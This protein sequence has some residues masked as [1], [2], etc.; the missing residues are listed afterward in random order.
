MTKPEWK[1]VGRQLFRHSGFVI[2]SDFV[3]RALSFL[4]YERPTTGP[5]STNWRRHSGVPSQ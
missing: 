1:Q 5:S 2:L 3:I 4:R